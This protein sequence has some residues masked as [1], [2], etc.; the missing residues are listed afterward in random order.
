[1]LQQLFSN[2]IELSAV[3]AICAA[4]GA[5]I[6]AYFA[7]RRGINLGRDTVI[8]L[9]RGIVQI[10]IVGFILGFVLTG[11][12]WLSWLVLLCMMLIAARIA[13]G[14]TKQIPGVMSLTLR[15]ILLGSGVVIVVMAFLG[16]IDTAPASLIPLGSIIIANA[17]NT[18]ALALE[19]F[20]SDVVAHVGLIEAGLALGAGPDVVVAPYAQA[21][22]KASMI[23]SINN[24]RSLGIV[25]IPGV[26]AGLLL[27]GSSPLNAAI[28]Q[29]VVVA[30]MFTTAASTS[31]LCTWFVRSHVF[32]TA[33]QLILRTS[34]R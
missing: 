14:R 30:M 2:P 11:D 23:P 22:V 26:M 21:T 32:T 31:L 33:D 34:D 25:W 9:L 28:Y 6:V 7:H 10:I 8:A 12:Q 29:F 13:A 17:M 1:M 20:R 27:A 4:I 15:S 16:V 5:L 19:R 3:Q 18:T 24:M